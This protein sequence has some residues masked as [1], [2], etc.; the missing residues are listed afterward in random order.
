MK[1]LIKKIVIVLVLMLGS[2]S[3]TSCTDTAEQQLEELQNGELQLI[4]KEELGGD[5]ED[6]EETGD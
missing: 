5:I 3:L 1:K 4:E 6:D 2:T